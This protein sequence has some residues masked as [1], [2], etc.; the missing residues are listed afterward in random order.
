[1]DPEAMGLEEGCDD[2]GLALR[3]AGRKARA[4]QDG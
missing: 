2:A 1:M 3:R 4:Q